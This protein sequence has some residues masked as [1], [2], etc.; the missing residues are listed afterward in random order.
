MTLLKSEI[1][2]E[3]KIDYIRKTYFVA[4]VLDIGILLVCYFNEVTYDADAKN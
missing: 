2:I 3:T 1:H 4:V